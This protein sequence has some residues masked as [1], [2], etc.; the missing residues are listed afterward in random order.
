MP[1][2]T[3]F[4]TIEI[5]A[6][7]THEHILHVGT[8]IQKSKVPWERMFR[9]PTPTCPLVKVSDIKYTVQ[10]RILDRILLKMKR[11]LGRNFDKSPM[12]HVTAWSTK[13]HLLSVLTNDEHYTILEC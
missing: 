8:Y 2:L 13:R 11:Y 6:V 4:E 10:V 7:E 1:Y 9:N 5:H 3:A 12:S